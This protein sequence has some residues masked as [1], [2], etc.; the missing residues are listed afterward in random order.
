MGKAL[1]L[2]K[3]WTGSR[4]GVMGQVRLLC[5]SPV[6]QSWEAG[7]VLGAELIHILLI[8]GQGHPFLRGLPRQKMDMVC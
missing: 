3:W 5:E 8:Q 6:G 4:P 1:F 7:A 2:V